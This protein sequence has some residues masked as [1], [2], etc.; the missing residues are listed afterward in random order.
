MENRWFSNDLEVFPTLALTKSILIAGRI[1]V[2]RLMMDKNCCAARSGIVINLVR[3]GDTTDH[4]GK[5]ITASETMRIKSIPVLCFPHSGGYEDKLVP[6]TSTR[7]LFERQSLI[8][9]LPC[10]PHHGERFK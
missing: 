6:C 9:N 10:G 8:L 7:G 5:V 2:F 3:L 4:G 1:F